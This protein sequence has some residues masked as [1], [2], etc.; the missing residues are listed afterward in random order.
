MR[1]RKRRSVV[2]SFEGSGV[3]GTAGMKEPGRTSVGP[4]RAPTAKPLVAV[5]L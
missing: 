2:R 1:M 3:Q 5:V 4:F